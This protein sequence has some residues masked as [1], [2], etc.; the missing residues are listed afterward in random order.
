MNAIQPNQPPL[1]PRRMPRTVRHNRRQSL[2]AAV[3]ETTAKVVV[4]AVLSAAAISGLVQL[5]P[6]HLSQQTKLREVR[7]EV[8]RTEER[9]KNL[10][11]DFNRSFDPGQAKSVMREQSTWVDPTQR[12][13]VWQEPG[14]KDDN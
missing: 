14:T 10:R 4:N 9:V 7:A 2:G 11:T 6:Y 1:Q 3:G 13:V 8:K 12:Q 5:F